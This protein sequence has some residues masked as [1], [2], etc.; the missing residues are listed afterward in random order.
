[1]RKENENNGSKAIKSGAVENV[2][3]YQACRLYGPEYWPSLS[4]TVAWETLLIPI[5]NKGLNELSSTSQTQHVGLT[6]TQFYLSSQCFFL[7]RLYL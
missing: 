1:M 4:L 3:I 7:A 6:N 5:R 2:I